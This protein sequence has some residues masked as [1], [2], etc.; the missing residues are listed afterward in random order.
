MARW[1]SG[2]S[3]N[4]LNVKL[5]WLR[6]WDEFPYFEVSRWWNKQ[7]KKPEEILSE[8]DCTFIEWKLI[9]VDTD[10]Y[11]Y[12]WRTMHSVSLYLADD[13][14]NVL[15]FQS[16]YTGI[17][18]MWLLKMASADHLWLLRFSVYVKD[19]KK[20]GWITNDGE[21]M[22]SKFDWEKEIKPLTD[23]YP[24]GTSDDVRLIEFLESDNV[25][26]EIRAKLPELK[27]ESE[28]TSDPIEDTS[29]EPEDDLPF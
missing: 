19:W 29:S 20:R 11:E 15:C 14:N 21:G 2:S 26:W 9:R 4:Y 27:A 6:K 12:E 18:K 22:E 28:E 8:P 23:W 17:M 10:E 1:K 16:S 5:K 13:Q 7:A 3:K 24:N 25:I